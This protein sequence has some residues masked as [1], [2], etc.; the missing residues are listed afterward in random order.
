MR[1]RPDLRQGSGTEN[2]LFLTFFFFQPVFS[3]SLKC[4]A[5]LFPYS[6]LSRGTTVTKRHF[7]V[8]PCMRMHGGTHSPLGGIQSH[9]NAFQLGFSCSHESS[10]F[11]SNC[12]FSVL[13]FFGAHFYRPKTRAAIEVYSSIYTRY[14]NIAVFR[15]T[16]SGLKGPPT[17]D[18]GI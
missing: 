16:V 3:L 11:F 14:D 13:S 12:V 1:V 2:P 15:H 10:F 7:I 8:S 4:G 18:V 9:V 5:I 6:L 17:D